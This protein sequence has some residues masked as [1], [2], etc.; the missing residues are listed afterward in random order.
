MDRSSPSIHFHDVVQTEQNVPQITRGEYS[1]GG[2]SNGGLTSERT[3]NDYIQSQLDEGLEG[4]FFYIGY[5]LNRNE[6]VNENGIIL[7]VQYGDLV[8]GDMYIHR[9]YIEIVKTATL[10]NGIFTTDL[11]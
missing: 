8:A 11:A 5:R 1:R 4:Q 6:R 2:E 10:T 9:S 7:Q 3:Y